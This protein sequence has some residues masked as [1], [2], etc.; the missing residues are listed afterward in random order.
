M[1]GASM[2]YRRVMSMV[3]NDVDD[4]DGQANKDNQ[5]IAQ[6]ILV[7]IFNCSFAPSFL[8]SIVVAS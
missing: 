2:N 4:S 6:P 8:L 3:V 1:L 7:N 5:K